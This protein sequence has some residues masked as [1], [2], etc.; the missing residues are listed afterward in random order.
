MF[1]NRGVASAALVAAL[2]VSATAL[3][4]CSKPSGPAETKTPATAHLSAAATSANDPPL[5]GM[6]PLIDPHN[7]YAADRPGNVSQTIARFPSRI[8]V[9][10]SGSNSVDVIDPVSFKIVEHFSVGRQPQHITPSDDL[11]APVGPERFG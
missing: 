7:I 10:N 4:S 5:P 1:S 2:S 11:R 3:E 6:P 8:Y 9:P